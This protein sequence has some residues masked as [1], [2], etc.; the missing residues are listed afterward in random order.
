METSSSTRSLHLPS[1]SIASLRASIARDSLADFIRQAWSVVEPETQLAWNWHLDKL[2]EVLMAVTSGGIKRLIINVPPGTGKSLIVSVLWPAWEWARTPH[3]RYLTFSY[4]DVN[5]IRDNRRLRDIVRSEWYQASFRSKDTDGVDD[6]PII[7][8]ASDQSGKIRFDTTARGWR[9]AS[10]VGGM[11]T[12]EHPHRIIIDDPLKA[13]DARSIAALTTCNEWYDRTISTRIALNPAIILIMQRLHM[14]D[15]SAHLLAKGGWTHVCFPM[16]YDSKLA[17]VYDLRDSPGQLLWPDLWPEDK[18]R[19][20]EISLGPFGTAGQLQQNPV[21]EGGGLFKREWLPIVDAAPSYSGLSMR[22]CRGWDTADTEDGGDWT[23]GVKLL[24]DISAGI[25]Y[26]LH[27]ER[28]R[29]GPGGVNSL[30]QN[31][32]ASDGKSCLIREGSG[33]GKAAISARSKMLAG[34]DYAVAQESADK[35]TRANPFRAQCEAGNVRLVRGDW[36]ESYISVLT[37]F[38]VGKHDDDVDGTSD[39]FNALIDA[40]VKRKAGTFGKK[41]AS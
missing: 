32:A 38:P 27:V 5:T 40:P 3:N 7:E 12:G 26:V 15:L 34:Y 14:A 23:V 24:H 20:E 31:V 35:V 39:A 21:P 28:T 19:E 8:L 16:R 33:S 22:M 11:G 29:S 10:S 36:N 9:I 37:S 18:V 25:W 1:L 13:E 4:T 2:C 17:N 30:I 41:R 6:G